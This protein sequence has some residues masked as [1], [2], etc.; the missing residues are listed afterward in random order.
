[1]L[2]ENEMQGY[3]PSLEKIINFFKEKYVKSN[4]VAKRKAGIESLPSIVNGYKNY[5]DCITKFT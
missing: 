5:N 4:D 3:R 1:M 2:V